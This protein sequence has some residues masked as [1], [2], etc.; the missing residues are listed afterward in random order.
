MYEYIVQK[1]FEFVGLNYY[2]EKIRQ[3]FKVPHFRRQSNVY[4]E[5]QQPK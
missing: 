5:D 2:N 4:V 1:G 3:K